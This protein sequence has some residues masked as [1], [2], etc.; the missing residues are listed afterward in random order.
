MIERVYWSPLLKWSHG[1][2]A[3]SNYKNRQRRYIGHTAISQRII[4]IVAVTMFYHQLHHICFPW[5]HNYPR[6]FLHNTHVS[7]SS[8]ISWS[9][10]LYAFLESDSIFRCIN[11]FII[12][13][14]CYFLVTW[15]RHV[16]L[17]GV[18][19][20]GSGIGLSPNRRKNTTWTETDL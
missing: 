2:F 13:N 6:F 17:W 16:A 4:N 19:N 7:Y 20:F 18:F 3:I 8:N 11:Q 14:R 5:I 12:Q 10:R 1:S 15:W 9:H